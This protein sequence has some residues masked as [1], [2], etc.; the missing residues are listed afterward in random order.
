MLLVSAIY[1][2]VP[3]QISDVPGDISLFKVVEAL[4][5]EK[6]ITQKELYLEYPR[7]WLVSHKS[8]S[9]Q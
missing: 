2:Y 5:T 6:N 7:Y 3:I 9:K 1:T 4:N 8:A